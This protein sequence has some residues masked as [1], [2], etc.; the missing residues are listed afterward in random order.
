MPM[1][2]LGCGF[3]SFHS[4]S[5]IIDSI[6]GRSFLPYPICKTYL[7]ILF[8]RS[9]L[10]ITHSLVPLQTVPISPLHFNLRRPPRGRCEK[11]VNAPEHTLVTLLAYTLNTFLV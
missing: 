8:G 7:V 9:C 4:Y 6:A 10:P 5:H 11:A 2:S 1:V 3:A